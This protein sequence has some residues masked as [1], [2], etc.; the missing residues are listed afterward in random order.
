MPLS[1]PPTAVDHVAEME[2]IGPL[3][4]D[5]LKGANFPATEKV[6][7]PLR[8]LLTQ[9]STQT[10]IDF[11]NYKSSTILRRVGRRMAVTHNP[12]IREYG[13]YLRAHPD[14]V[15]ELVRAFLINVTG[16][17]RSRQGKRSY[18]AALVGRLRDG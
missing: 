8:D 17:F 2:Q 6:E 5:I 13:D 15:K 4:F 9:V 10:S 14:E 1:L 12:N 3:L 7:D 16:F 18:S 11:R